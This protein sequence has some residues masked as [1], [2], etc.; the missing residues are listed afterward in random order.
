MHLVTITRK[1]LRMKKILA[2]IALVVIVGAAIFL[3]TAEADTGNGIDGYVFV[4]TNGDLDPGIGEPSL[5]GVSVAVTASASGAAV[6]AQTDSLGYYEVD[7]LVAGEYEVEVAPPAGYTCTASCAVTVTVTDATVTRVDWP[8]LLTGE[9]T[10]TPSPPPTED[11]TETPPPTEEPNT[12]TP[13]SEPSATPTPTNTPTLPPRD[14][15]EPSPSPTLEPTST[16]T[17]EP[18][19]TDTPVPEMS[20]SI[21]PS[22]GAPGTYF[23]V[24]GTGYEPSEMVKMWLIEPDGSITQLSGGQASSSGGVNLAFVAPTD[25]AQGVY[26]VRVRGKSS[27]RESGA[28]FYIETGGATSTPWPTATSSSDGA[29]ASPTPRNT[30][31]GYSDPLL[32]GITTMGGHSDPSA[33]TGF[34]TM[35]WGSVLVLTIVLVIVSMAMEQERS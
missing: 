23:S 7:G 21:S 35:G 4:D 1:E 14:T 8:L 26:T 22:S 5:G 19:P 30:A 11:P 20:L 32:A 18:E 9:A 2:G 31:S 27:G 29:E 16:P 24:V 3:G 10:A 17:P 25:L 13:T 15:P 6:E 12:P 33:D 34:R 28:S